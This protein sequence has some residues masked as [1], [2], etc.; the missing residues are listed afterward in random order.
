MV[1]ERWGVTLRGAEAFTKVRQLLGSRVEYR[2]MDAFALD[3]LDETF[4]FVYCCGILHRVET[5]LP[6]CES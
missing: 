1:Q 6:C 3:A 4:D 2:R 5:R